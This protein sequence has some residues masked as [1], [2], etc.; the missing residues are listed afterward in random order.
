MNAVEVIRQDIQWA[1][2]LLE[3]VMQDVTP[4]QS[5]WLPPGIANPLGA[6]YAHALLAEDAV[7]NQLLRGAQ[8]LFESTWV[9]R[10]GVSIPQMEATPEW[11]RS[12]RVNLPEARTYAQAV[13]AATIEYLDA[14]EDVDLDQVLDLTAQH[15]GHQTL[16]WSLVALVAGHIHNMAGEI[17]CLKGLQGV[18]GYPF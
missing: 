6:Q 15:L 14:L 9:N 5:A 18:S 10:T 8:P 2:D 7:V 1:H 13:Y 12:V 4:E 3:L 16:G 17:S 11:S